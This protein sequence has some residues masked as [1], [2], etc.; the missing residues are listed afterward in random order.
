VS[1]E[2]GRGRRSRGGSRE[3]GG[4][5][6]G[7][8]PPG[9]KPR[10][11]GGAP[12]RRRPDRDRSRSAPDRGRP[13]PP[14]RQTIYGRNAVAEALRG[15]RR[16]HRVWATDGARRELPAV[17]GVPV[18]AADEDWLEARCGSPD[19]QG[20]CA[21]VD[22]YPYADA[23]HLLHAEDALVVC[24]DEV[25]DPRNLGA[26]CRVAECAGAS[27][28]V[29]PERRSAEVTPAACKASAGAVEHL[30]VARV[31]N[32]ADWLAEAK[33]AGAW[34]YGADAGGEPY[35]TLDFDGRVVLVL[36]SEGRGLRPRVEAACDAVVS[37][38]VRGRVGSLNVSA[39]AAALLYG[40]LQRRLDSAP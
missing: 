38:P 9:G 24:L 15:R 10:G 39:A 40:I 19:H 22:P 1:A 11:G 20:A 32:V 37:L 34:V 31:R 26:V 7:A 29:I 2:R 35:A 25:Q 28:V 4:K 12:E 5:G 30:A 16:V 8:K 13:G 21:D 17:R 18:D 33:R 36:G 23:A 6:H 27:G 14:A 3:G